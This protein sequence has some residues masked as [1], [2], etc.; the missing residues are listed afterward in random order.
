M[1]KSK[2]APQANNVRGSDSDETYRG[3]APTPQ[4]DHST[5]YFLWEYV[6]PDDLDDDR[7]LAPQL[8]ELWAEFVRGDDDA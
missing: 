1:L 4:G 3:H 6:D 8:R 5:H 7:P 2:Y